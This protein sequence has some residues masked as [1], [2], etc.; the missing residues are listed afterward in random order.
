MAATNSMATM[1]CDDLSGLHVLDVGAIEREHQHIATHRDCRAAENDD[2]VDHLL[3]AVEAVGRRMVMPDDAAAALEPFD[4]DPIRDVA[5]DPHEED[6]NDAERER[7]AQIVVRVFRP[8]AT[9]R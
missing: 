6:Q 8:F 3:A 9:R 4:I 5:G 1:P 7:E 2:P